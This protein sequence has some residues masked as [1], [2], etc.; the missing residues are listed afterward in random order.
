MRAKRA[1][2][3]KTSLRALLDAGAAARA[4]GVS[5]GTLYTYVSRGLIRATPH[6][7]VAK[8]SL[9]PLADV[10]ALIARKTRSRRPRAAAASALELGLPV[11]KTRITHFEDDRYFYRGRDAIVFSREATLEDAARLLWA[12]DGSDPFCSR[13]FDP[14]EVEG[15]NAWAARL[16]MAR[17]PDRAIAL[18]PLL[19]MFGV[20]PTADVA[21]AARVLHAVIAAVAGIEGPIEGRIHEAV[22]AAWGK[23]TAADVVRR[24]L[25]M[26][27][28]HELNA[29][30]FAVRVV[31]STGAG[32]EHC[33]MGGLAAVGGPRHG[34]AS[35]GLRALLAGVD[36]NDAGRA[37]AAHFEQHDRL[38][39]FGHTFYREV[40]PRAVELLSVIE[41]DDVMSAVLAAGRTMSGLEPNVDFALLAVERSL[42]LPRGAALAMFAIGR[43]VGWIAHA[44][45]QRTS[46][47]L[48]RPRAEFVLE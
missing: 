36:R 9:Y 35:E 23:P 42:G 19:P 14:Q 43:S 32:L 1:R 33:V 13:C 11:L 45:E 8:A 25:V 2:H 5:K 6:P 24:A 44:F 41:L 22:A 10:Q 48:I 7:S 20:R 15:W 17:G 46:G 40:D 28:D 27:A 21:D 47:R 38:P 4:L 34:G 3:R 30:T 39:G 18:L 37:V 29:S 12:C 16:P 31:A 26:L